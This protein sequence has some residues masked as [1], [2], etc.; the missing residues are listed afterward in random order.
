MVSKI[1][2]S[3]GSSAKPSALLCGCYSCSFKLTAEGNPEDFAEDPRESE[4][5]DYP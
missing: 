2:F 3:L 5:G 4:L 1:G